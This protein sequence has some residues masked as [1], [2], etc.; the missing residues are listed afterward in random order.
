MTRRPIP[1]K[2]TTGKVFMIHTIISKFVHHNHLQFVTGKQ[3]HSHT[4]IRTQLV[5]CRG[6]FFPQH[7]RKARMRGKLFR[8]NRPFPIH[9]Y[10]ASLSRPERS[11][12]DSSA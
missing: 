12:Y 9:M 11:L 10:G 1:P 4:G 7:R 5:R 2:K 8:S 3:T 6:T